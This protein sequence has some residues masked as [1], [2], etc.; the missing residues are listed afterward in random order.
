MSAV[1]RVLTC[2]PSRG[3][4]S[5]RSCDCD[6]FAVTG[7]VSTGPGAHGLYVSCDSKVLY[8]TNRGVGTISLLQ[9]ATNTVTR[10]WVIPGGSPDMGG[11]SADGTKLWISGRHRGAVYVI[12]TTTGALLRTINVGS[13][14]TGYAS[15]PDQAATRSATPAS[16]ANPPARCRHERAGS[17]R[18]P[19]A[20]SAVTTPN[21]TS[22]A[23]RRLNATGPVSRRR[24]GVRRGELRM[25]VGWSSSAVGSS[26]LRSPLRR[27]SRSRSSRS[28]RRMWSRRSSSCVRSR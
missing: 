17:S 7:F 12:D 9:F 21:R 13:V 1:V 18:P 5:R 15:T 19:S 28:D 26:R 6:A 22:E 3:C 20:A 8:V 25:V 4:R 24:P 16:F 27:S 23:R 11:V 14:P 2:A 10:T